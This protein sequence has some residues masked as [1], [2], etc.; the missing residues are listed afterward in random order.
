MKPFQDHPE[1]IQ[2]PYNAELNMAGDHDAVALADISRLAYKSAY[3]YDKTFNSNYTTASRGYVV[4]R[5]DFLLL[6]RIKAQQQLHKENLQSD[7]D[8]GKVLSSEWMSGKLLVQ[9]HAHSNMCV[10]DNIEDVVPKLPPRK[11][12]EVSDIDPYEERFLRYSKSKYTV[13]R[14]DIEEKKVDKTDTVDDERRPP[15]PQRKTDILENAPSNA[16][17]YAM[18]GRTEGTVSGIVNIKYKKD[19]DLI[20]TSINDKDQKSPTKEKNKPK[21]TINPVVNR[22]SKPIDFLDSVHNEK[23]IID[24][25]YKNL[26]GTTTPEVPTHKNLDY[27]E[28]LQQHHNTSIT[29]KKEFT[30]RPPVSNKIHVDYLDSMQ[31]NSSTVITKHPQQS[32]FTTNSKNN[33]SKFNQKS[34]SESNSESFIESALKKSESNYSLSSKKKPSLP[35]KPDTLTN[36]QVSFSQKKT[37]TTKNK[38]KENSLNND[39]IEVPP[40]RKIEK[41]QTDNFS[42]KK[43][44]IQEYLDLPELKSVKKDNSARPPIN[45]STKPTS[46]E[47][48][49]LKSVKKDKVLPPPVN[50]NTKPNL[51]EA[52]IKHAN[53]RTNDTL[54]KRNILKS[55]TAPAIPSRKISMPEALK[56]AKELKE[57]RSRKHINN[58]VPTEITTT[59]TATN[60][61]INPDCDPDNS[62]AIEEKL[63]KILLLQKRHTVNEEHPSNV[64]ISNSTSFTITPSPSISNSSLSIFPENSTS[65]LTHPTK[66]RARGPKRKLPTK[67]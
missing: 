17:R 18:L 36:F 53:L 47:L 8:N 32:D 54:S 11:P 41:P 13:K 9:N 20:D 23:Y 27:L 55:K 56:R 4:S 3:N 44:Q 52:L 66:K 39:R 16:N 24:G 62:L 63:S 61:I 28:S 7:R 38:K 50:K 21:S 14:I 46:I 40:L 57:K 67:I 33:G 1:I 49:K 45:K 22:A 43:N 58:T 65:S 10:N 31:E 37:T 2:Y 12:K 42:P 19:I 64:S 48:P 29:M 26:V 15:L 51:P 35:N 30:S 5:D 60:D 25:N 59:I 34:T 6:Q